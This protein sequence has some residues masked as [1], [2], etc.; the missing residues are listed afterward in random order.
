MLNTLHSEWGKTWS[1]RAPFACLMGTVIVVLVTAASLAN[2]TLVSIDSGEVPH[3]TTVPA[4]DSVASGL[5]FGQLAFA[6]FALQLITSEYA[7]GVIRSTLQAQPRR[8]LV[9]LAKALIA[10]VVGAVSGLTL[11]GAAGLSSE[12]IL[13]DRLAAGRTVA[14]MSLT[15]GCMLAAV[16]VLVVGLGAALRS[17]VGTLALSGVV[18]V[19]TLALPDAVGRWAPGQA[20]AALLDGTGAYYGSAVGLAILTLWAASSLGLGVWLLERRDA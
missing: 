13:G 2:D 10:A 16:G 12:V 17:A 11:G 15:A 19:G 4:I 18:L 14:Q 6:A 7:T 8:H 20:G 9:L 5:Q 1:V 3:D